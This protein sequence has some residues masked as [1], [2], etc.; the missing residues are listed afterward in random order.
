MHIDHIVL[1]VIGVLG[2]GAGLYLLAEA[3]KFRA[4]HNKKAR[5]REVMNSDLDEGGYPSIQK[6]YDKHCRQN[7]IS[8][9]EK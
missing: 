2:V 6:M 9:S 4:C 3:R 7:N 1:I 8:D 5:E